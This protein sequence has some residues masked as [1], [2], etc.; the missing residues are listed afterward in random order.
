MVSS[1]SMLDPLGSSLVFPM[2]SDWSRVLGLVDSESLEST[3]SE[4]GAR[5]TSFMAMAWMSLNISSILA[6]I[7]LTSSWENGED[8]LGLAAIR[9]ALRRV[10]IGSLGRC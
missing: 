7:S 4:K 5:V 9:R 1:S 10:M 3:V 6:L 8:S 2:V